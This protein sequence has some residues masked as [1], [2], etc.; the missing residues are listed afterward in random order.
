MIA[1]TLLALPTH[2]LCF[3]TSGERILM[4]HR[5]K[6]PNRGMWNG[7]GGRIE[8][9]E[10]PYAACLREVSEETGLQLNTARFS[11]LLS[12]CTPVT[13]GALALYTAAAPSEKVHGCD[14]G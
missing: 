9:G 14:E 2:T 3:L 8:E 10:T 7:V 13:E 1:S 4:L 6:E 11:G 12:W 5:R